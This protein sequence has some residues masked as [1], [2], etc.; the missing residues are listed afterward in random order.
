M[1]KIITRV[2]DEEII[3]GLQDFHHQHL[4]EHEQL[5]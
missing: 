3:N 4:L 2:K 5:N 1:S